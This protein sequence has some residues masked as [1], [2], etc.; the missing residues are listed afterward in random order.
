MTGE[1]VRAVLGRLAGVETGTE[2]SGEA[3]PDTAYGTTIER[4]RAALDDLDAAAD[5]VED[6]G[7]ERLEAAVSRAESDLSGSAAAGRET[8]EAFRTFR[9]VA[10]G[11]QA[12]G[13]EDLPPRD[14]PNE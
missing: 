10:R 11:I 13:S 7:L 5:F 12:E 1:D 4:A 6:G 9:A 14:R 2:T 8:L 3:L